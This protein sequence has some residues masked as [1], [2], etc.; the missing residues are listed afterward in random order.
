MYML[1]EKNIFLILQLTILNC[2]NYWFMESV[3]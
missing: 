2:D 3:I 1:I